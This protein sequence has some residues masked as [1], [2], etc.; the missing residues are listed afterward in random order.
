MSSPSRSFGCFLLLAVWGTAALS[1]EWTL[2]ISGAVTRP[3]MI[4]K[5]VFDTFPRRSTVAVDPKGRTNEYQGVPLYELLLKAGA[6]S[7]DSI[8]GKNLMLYL[9]AEALDGYKVVYA[10]P[11]I[12]T[13]FTNRI[14]L[15]AD[16]KNGGPLQDPEAPLEIIVP[17]EKEHA[18]WIRQLRA[19][20]LLRSNE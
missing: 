11:E 14:I 6:P 4:T 1:Q 5:S 2:V 18:R 17:G 20:K 15:V 7:G 8:H 12:D 16:T 19:L 10:L 13:L 9:Q 3:M